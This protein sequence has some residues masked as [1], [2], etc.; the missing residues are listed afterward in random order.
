M[1]KLIHII[2]TLKS[3]GAENVLV[4]LVEEFDKLGVEQTIITLS[5]SKSDFYYNKVKNFC[6]VLNSKKNNKT[7]NEL[8]T[9]KEIK[10]IA[11]MYK[12]ILYIQLKLFLNGINKKVY[13]NI[14][15]SNFGIFQF[16]QKLSLCFF[17]FLSK[18]LGP[19]IIY[20]SNKSKIVHNK[21]FFSR[22]KNI[23][24]QNNLAKKFK[25]ISL[26]KS[27]LNFKFFLFV[28]RFHSQKSPK[29][30]SIIAENLLLS[31]P[32]FKLVIVGRNWK[33]NYFPKKIR[34]MIHIVGE[35]NNLESY[36]F[37]SQCMFFTSKF[38]EGYPNVLVEA[39]AFGT[40]IVGFDAGD[41]G[42]I[43]KDY[44]FGHLV[45]NNDEFISKVESIIKSKID[46]KERNQVMNYQK[47][48]LSFDKTVKKY[49]SFLFENL[50]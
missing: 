34:S 36:Y 4:R 15:H 33:L 37:N 49:Y 3:G 47:K 12:S 35:S 11:W 5:D 45:S 18:I 1:K 14:R 13:W 31:N 28:G 40:P 44:K 24:I 29:S 16:Y 10:I 19:W 42:E 27:F 7:I 46:S 23:V 30:L 22:E 20:C 41:S 38:G 9:E 26:H 6:N 43:L 48:V 50:N 39:S 2:P 8:L 17:G 25:N 21:F 32:D